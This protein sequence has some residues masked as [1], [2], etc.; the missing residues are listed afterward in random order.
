M[1][2]ALVAFLTI[3]GLWLAQCK[4]ENLKQLSTIVAI[5]VLILGLSYW[6]FTHWLI[7]PPIVPSIVSLVLAVPLIL[8]HRSFGASRELDAQISQLIQAE[9]WLWPSARAAQTDPA[10]PE[11]HS[12][13]QLPRAKA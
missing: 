4:M 2:A 10:A 3:G 8:L 5:I 9:N 13:P 11:L 6:A 12:Y 7:Y 1:C